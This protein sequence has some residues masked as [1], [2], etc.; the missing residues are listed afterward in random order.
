[1]SS[2]WRSSIQQPDQYNKRPVAV[3]TSTNMAIISASS[4]RMFTNYEISDEICR[5]Q[6]QVN[7]YREKNV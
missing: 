2:E 3:S 5:K 7:K 1:M 4:S 6:V